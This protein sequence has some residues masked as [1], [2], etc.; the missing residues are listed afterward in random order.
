M[1]TPNATRHE[2]V[3]RVLDTVR[4]IQH[5]VDV[6]RLERIWSIYRSWINVHGLEGGTGLTRDELACVLECPDDDT[7]LDFLLTTFGTSERVDL[8]TLLITAACVARG[9]LTEKARLLFRLVDF[10]VEDEIVEDELVLIVASCM[11]GLYRLGVVSS[12]VSDADARAIAYEAF[13]FV[14]VDDGSKMPLSQFIKWMVAHPRP[15]ALF[16]RLQ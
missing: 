3:L 4:T 16:E 6:A 11:H 10:D 12:D 2:D 7:Q 5:T 9:S 8:L 15:R 1:A 14:G 13:E